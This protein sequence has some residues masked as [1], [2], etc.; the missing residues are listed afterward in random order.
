MVPLAEFDNFFSSEL[1]S[2]NI[3]IQQNS[4]IQTLF[5]ERQRQTVYS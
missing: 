5:L 3:K 4:E 1:N 2:E